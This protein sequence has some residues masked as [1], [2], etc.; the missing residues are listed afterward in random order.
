MSTA[1]NVAKV[2]RLYDE[3]NGGNLDV[4]DEIMAPNFATHGETMGLQPGQDVRAAMKQGIMWAR[5]IMPDLKVSILDT[6]AEGD[7]VAC[8]LVF[9]G[10]H[11]GTDGQIP[12]TGNK[13]EYTAIA[14]NRFENG[15]MVERWFNSDEMGMM[16][17]MGLLPSMQG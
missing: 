14:I 17:Q 15:K 1:D 3:I 11:T 13:V 4:I 7:K 16:R 10:T 5:M 2:H 9:V 8:R 12:A 6:V